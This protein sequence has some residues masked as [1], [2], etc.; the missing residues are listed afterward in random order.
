MKTENLEARKDIFSISSTYDSFSPA[1]SQSIVCIFPHLEKLQQ[2]CHKTK[3]NT[4]LHSCSV[5]AQDVLI[6]SVKPTNV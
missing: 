4:T 2:L 6:I 3:L 5:V 1:S